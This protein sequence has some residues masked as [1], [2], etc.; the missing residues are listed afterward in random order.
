MAHDTV[1]KATEEFVDWMEFTWPGVEPGTTRW[2]DIRE[3]WFAGFMN[4]YLHWEERE[5]DD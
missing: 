5:E 1:E 4:C 3:A 2:M